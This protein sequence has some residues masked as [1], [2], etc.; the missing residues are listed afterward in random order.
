M[1]R[2]SSVLAGVAALAAAT[3]A[4]AQPVAPGAAFASDISPFTQAGFSGSPQAG[5]E[6]RFGQTTGGDDAAERLGVSL[7]GRD[8]PASEGRW[9][10]FAGAR[11]GQVVR[12]PRQSEAR[13][14]SLGWND[15][16]ATASMTSAQAGIALRKGD[17]QA[18]FGYVRRK[19]KVSGAQSDLLA[20][21][22]KSDHVAGF[23]FSW[24]LR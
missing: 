5:A 24:T 14:A 12:D 23:S 13:W 19:V 2:R 10:L 16:R 8:G 18:S 22:P 20:N 4:H 21:M 17:A 7:G 9:F 15:E 11:S 6:V 3:A 1:W